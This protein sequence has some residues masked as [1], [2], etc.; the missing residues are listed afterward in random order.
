MKRIP[1]IVCQSTLSG[2]ILS[3]PLALGACARTST[4]DSPAGPATWPLAVYFATVVIIV[5]GMLTLSYV[6]GEKHRQ[7]TTG[8]P[9]ESGMPP[10]GS[11]RLRFDVKFYLVA[12]LFLVFDLEAT[13]LYP[14]AVVYH[15]L[16]W[17]GFVEMLVFIAVLLAGYLY[18]VKRGALE[19]D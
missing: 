11:A 18:I 19:W 16:G 14:W 9:Y 5:A 6:L 1:A 17:F 4:P 8:E 3:A 2:L 12:I 13:Y 15:K 7:R 10:T